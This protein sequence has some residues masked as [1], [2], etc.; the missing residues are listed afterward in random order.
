HILTPDSTDRHTLSLHD[1][2]PIYP[3]LARRDRQRDIVQRDESAEPDAETADLEEDR[4]GPGLRE[5]AR[6]GGTRVSGVG[7]VLANL[8]QPGD[9]KSTRLNS[10]HVKN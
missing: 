9:R 4:L 7:H 1:A 8:S 3:H 5:P 10:S 6:S 2:L